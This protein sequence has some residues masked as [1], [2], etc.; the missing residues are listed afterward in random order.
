MGGALRRPTP[1]HRWFEAIRTWVVDEA[2]LMGARRAISVAA[3]LVVGAVV[4]WWLL[5]P[6]AEPVEAR[7]PFAA[8]VT[9]AS[10]TPSTGPPSGV[11][12]PGTIVVHIAGEVQR[13]GL[14]E[15]VDGARV[16]DAVDAAGGATADGQVHALNLAAPVRDG[17]RIH[18]PHR[19]EVAVGAEPVGGTAGEASPASGAL[20][21]LNLA[22]ADQLTQLP[23]VGP[24]IAAAIV[25]YRER[26]GP[27]ASVD[28][29]LEVPGIGPAKLEA[30][31][32]LATV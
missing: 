2:R 14:V 26:R 24:S 10:E 23:G 31:R 12:T 18:V 11:S 29:L 4:V 5:R 1:S 25:A 7:L 3:A 6:A 22:D 20:V 17:Q 8:P 19:D 30:L 32:D 13:P 16:A 21:N 27:F 9:A 28:A 15:L